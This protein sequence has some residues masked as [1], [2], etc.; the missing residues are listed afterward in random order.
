[1]SL[2]VQVA[3]GFALGCYALASVLVGRARRTAFS[4]STCCTCMRCWW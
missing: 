4:R 1:M 2:I 3:T